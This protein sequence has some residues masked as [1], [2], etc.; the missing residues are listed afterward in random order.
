[1]NVP[2]NGCGQALR[3]AQATATVQPPRCHQPTTPKDERESAAEQPSSS[4][5]IAPV[6]NVDFVYERFG[7]TA[8][9]LRCVT[10]P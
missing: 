9:L 2:F 7:G 8:G 4:F 6:V 10:K 5:E 3:A 1:M